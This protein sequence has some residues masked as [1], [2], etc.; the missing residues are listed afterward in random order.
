ML[1]TR[2]RFRVTLA[3]GPREVYMPDHVCPACWND[4]DNAIDACARVCSR[5]AFR[6]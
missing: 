1:A 4:V 3:D 5:C 6:W 2:S